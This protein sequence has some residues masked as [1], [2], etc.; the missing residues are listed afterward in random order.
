M[1]A[2]MPAQARI[3]RMEI[4]KIAPAF[5]GQSFGA[6]GA[7]ERVIGKAYGEVDPKAPANAAIQDIDLAPVNARGMVEYSTDIDILRPA[8][9]AKGNKVLLFNI[10]N[11]GN[12]GAEDLFNADVR[13]PLADLNAV[14]AP[15][16]G[17]LQRQGYTLIW[18]GWQ[19]DVLPGDN[20]MTFHVPAARNKDGSAVTGLVRSE[21]VVRAPTTTLM[22]GSGWFTGL[23]HDSY[24]TVSTEN[25]TPLAD[26]FLPT[27]TVRSRES[28][29]REPIA[30]T[31]W[32]FGACDAADEPDPKQICLPSGFQPGKLYELVYRARDPLVMGLGFAV[33]RDLATY[34]KTAEKD[35]A[36]VA[37]PVAHGNDTRAIVMGTSQSGRMIRTFIH[38]GFN[39]GETGRRVFEGALP[40]IGGGLLPLNLRFAQPGRAWGQQIDHLFPAYD[41]PFTYASETDPL[42]GRTQGILDRC[43][44]S[45]TCPQ[46][47]HAATALEMWEGRQSLGLTDP[48]GQHDAAEPA[49]V[50]TYIM[51]STQ[52]GPAPLPLPTK[53]PFG[54][55]ACVQQPNP[56]PH[57]WTMRAL[58][59]ALTGWVRDGT[60]PP[61]STVP[62]IADATLVPPDAVRFPS[63]PANAYGG[64]ERPAV[65][66]TGDVNALH[67][68]DFGP[69]YRAGDTGGVIT[70][71][72]PRVGTASYAVLVPQVDADGNDLGG[73]RDV[74]EA[75]PIGT[76][77]AWNHFRADW[78]D[79]GFCNFN[80]SFIPF[81]ATKA[82]R[83]A[84]GDPRPSIEERYPDRAAYAEAVRRA[85]DALV[86]QR[87]LLPQDRDR[88]VA[89]AAKDGV[90]AGP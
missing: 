61:P 87:L 44:A 36:G 54:G 55:N 47:I 28:A 60:A 77:T 74:Y 79:G 56:N 42:T 23:T 69:E 20:R 31:A 72:P 76:Y 15:G 73:V 51:V 59:T 14:K 8:D 88:L 7:F 43:T 85:S 32:R 34:L 57:T 39:Q 11:R 84:A 50:R 9:P 71:E 63:I 66:Y 37:N 16:D 53:A 24:P 18:F 12:K 30:N 78:F 45:A 62:R 13:A 82:E 81:A 83:L 38:L 64:V 4:T 89:E 22:L 27:L 5:G 21:L 35:D 25:R 65:R 49:N 1:L 75:A 40:H 29:P 3:T 2:T 19:A 26:G 46:I 67:V 90:R 58:L 80:G 68:L 33:T 41:F 10:L 70:V 17:W 48:L 86:E 52:H 6:A